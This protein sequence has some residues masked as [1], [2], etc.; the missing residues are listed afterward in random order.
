RGA[1]FRCILSDAPI[2]SDYIKAEGKAGRLGITM[3]AIVVAGKRERL[4]VSPTEEHQAAAGINCTENSSVHVPIANDQRALWCLLYGITHFDHL[5]TERQLAAMSCL[6]DLVRESREII[7]RHAEER[8]SSRDDI[9]LSA[10]GCGPRAY[11]EAISIYLSFA[12]SKVADRNTMVT[13]WMHQRDS[14]HSTFSK[15]GLPMSWDFVEVNAIGQQTGGFT[16]SLKWTIEALEG[17]AGEGFGR[18]FQADASKV[19][20]TSH[21]F[22]STDPPYYDN[23]GYA[24]LSDFFYVWLR[25]S[26][27]EVFPL[28]FATI[29]VPKDEELIAS[30]YRHGSK[31][32]AESFFLDGMRSAMKRFALYSNPTAPLTIYYAFKQSETKSA[33]GTSSTGWITFLDAVHHAGLALTGTWPMRT[34]RSER[35]VSIGTNSLASSIVLVCRPRQPN[36]QSVSR[37]EFI[38]ELNANLPMALDA[39]TRDNEG[40]PSPVAPVDLSQAIIGP[41]MAIFSKYAAVLEADGSPMTVRTAL[42]LINR[43]LAEDDFDGDTQFCLHWFETHGWE[44]GVFG[45]A[46]V[47]ARAKATSVGGLDDAGVIRSGGGKVK[48]LRW[49]EYP[50]DWDPNKDL[51]LPI[52]ETLHQMIR[53]FRQGGES[54]AGDLLAQPSV[55]SRAEAARQLAYRLYTLCERKNWAE[56][57]RAYNELITSWSAIE[58]A[59]PQVRQGELF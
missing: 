43:F 52:W 8:L 31:Q 7:V 10:G 29:S 46:D 24:D 38:R 45:E 25:R 37:R 55:Q 12:L 4:Y 27:R 32:K 58:T 35:S 3:L 41:G 19:D 20:L 22:I 47:L 6:G 1:N 36:A 42:Q 17:A 21:P 56:D 34:E 50:A 40:L 48:L 5:F 49:S 13:R 16:E 23:I 54:A 44:P 59:A 33:E 57:A 51:R 2:E 14:M 39:M 18:A 26:L 53:A 30:P 9:G 28:L 11:A 15:Q